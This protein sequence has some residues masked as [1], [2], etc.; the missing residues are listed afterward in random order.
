MSDASN[1]LFLQALGLPAPWQ[2]K[3]SSLTSEPSWGEALK[4]GGKVLEIELDYP[5]GSA[6]PCPECGADCP[7]HDAVPRTWRH[8][9]F[10]QHGT[11]LR[12]PSPRVRCPT[13][14]T[15]QAQIPWARSG[16]GFTLLFEAL[17]MTLVADMPVKAAAEHLHEHDTRLWRV[18]RHY[19]GTAH[20]QTSWEGMHTVA[21]DETST[22]KGHRYATTIVDLDSP[23]TQQHQSARL[24]LMLEGKD[25]ENIKRFTE[26]MPKHGAKAQQITSAAID[27][28]RAFIRGVTEHL[29]GA[30]IVFDRYHVMALCGKAVDTSRRE[31][32]AQ[33][34]PLKG[35]LWALRG[36]AANLK[37]KDL[38][39]RT[40]LCKDWAQI[41][42]AMAL[43][44]RLQELWNYTTDPAQAAKQSP[45]EQATE[46]LKNW[47]A[48]A[49]R[50]RLPSFVKLA[51]TLREHS[52]GILGYYHNRTT[53]AA[54][55]AINGLI[56]NARRRARGYRNFENLQAISYWTAGLLDLR[57]SKA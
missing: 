30:K 36:N 46:H 39:R 26:E 5:K 38:Q 45:L 35:A 28:G 29:P 14:G 41:A 33:G 43:R 16:S 54:I 24:I 18:L 12:A 7:I 53:S 19:V 13:H 21:F 6:F 31:L 47:C 9:D 4:P 51:R 11:Y 49:Q 20:A 17:I 56:Q 22:R 57:L 55:E 3:R 15:R 50:S 10:W 42:R 44:E 34:I 40:E 25:A 27:M 23:V 48:W 2:V 37:E 1:A 8:M 32:Q 52:S